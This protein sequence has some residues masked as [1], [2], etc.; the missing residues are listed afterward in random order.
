M[1]TADELNL[2]IYKRE[3]KEYKKFKNKIIKAFTSDELILELKKRKV[4][5]INWLKGSNYFEEV[6]KK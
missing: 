1:E 6:E 4:L 3:L 2:P 5:R